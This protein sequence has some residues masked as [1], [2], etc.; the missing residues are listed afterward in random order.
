MKYIIT[1]EQSKR[2]CDTI[3]R[4]IKSHF[5]ESTW[6][7]DITVFPT[8]SDEDEAIFDIYVHLNLSALKIYNESGQHTISL[9]IKHK[10]M[11]FIETWFPLKKDDFY[12]GILAKDC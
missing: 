2:V 10:V 8:E 7:C 4:M 1:E 3:T 5:S 6:I 12:V 11:D 9:S